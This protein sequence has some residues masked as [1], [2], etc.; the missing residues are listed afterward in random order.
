MCNRKEGV[1]GG[2]K[3]KTM[4]LRFFIMTS[5]TVPSPCHACHPMQ[6]LGQGETNPKENSQVKCLKMSKEFFKS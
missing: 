5:I 6:N 4:L 1:G 2:G 3:K